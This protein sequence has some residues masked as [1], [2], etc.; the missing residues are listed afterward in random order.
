MPRCM[1][2]PKSTFNLPVLL[3]IWFSY[4]NIYV[5]YCPQK[6]D[7]K[8]TIKYIQEEKPSLQPLR[9]IYIDLYLLYVKYVPATYICVCFTIMLFNCFFSALCV[10]FHAI[11]LIDF[12]SSMYI[13]ISC[14]GVCCEQPPK[15][16]DHF[17]QNFAHTL[18]WYENR[19]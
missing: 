15:R 9:S 18:W 1:L 10:L 16:L 6:N 13:K 3:N 8:W 12:L 19:F 11:K 5:A 4:I 14:H 2:W 7:K 17:Q